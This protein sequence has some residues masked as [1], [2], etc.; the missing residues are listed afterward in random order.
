MMDSLQSRWHHAGV[1][2]GDTLLL[3]SNIKRTLMQYRRARIKL[4]PDDILDSFLDAVGPDGTLLMP[5]FNFDFTQGA[6]FDIRSTPSQMGALTEAARRHPDAVRTGHPVY[7]FA[8]IGHHASRFEKLD[9]VSAYGDESPFAMLRDLDGKVGVLDL[10]DQHSMTFYH[11]VEEIK[12]VGYRYDKT[13]SGEY[14]GWDGST[15]RKSY[16]LYVRDLAQGVLTDVDA[17][18]ELLW[19]TGIYQGDRPGNGSGLRTARAGELFGF[20]ARL[21]DTEQALGTLYSIRRAA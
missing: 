5:L 9:N 15:T 18:G 13:F 21:I 8:V 12:Q 3:H 14:T 6:A 17:A 19:Q 16:T 4:T 7:S 11:H 1:E 10:P 20:V 2:P